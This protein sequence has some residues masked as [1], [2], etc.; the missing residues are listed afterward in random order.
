TFVVAVMI[1]GLGAVVAFIEGAHKLSE[2]YPVEHVHINYIVLGVSML[3]EIGSWIVAFREFRRA[4]GGRSWLAAAR[5][6]KDPTIF[7][8]LFEDT[9]ALLGL[10][11]AFAGVALADLLGQPIFDGLAALATG[12]ILRTTAA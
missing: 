1:F 11:A 4:Q 2:P 9:A 12:V 10:L 6:S 7:T 5:R 3:F 8:V